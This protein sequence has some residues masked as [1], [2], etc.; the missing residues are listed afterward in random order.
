LERQQLL[1]EPDGLV[2]FSVVLVPDGLA[3]QTA[4]GLQRCS[5]GVSADALA[6]HPHGSALLSIHPKCPASADRHVIAACLSSVEEA[7]GGTRFADVGK[8][9]TTAHAGTFVPAPG[10]GGPQRTARHR[11]RQPPPRGHINL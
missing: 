10:S 4:G 1:V 11:P 3:E 2:R 6:L 5:S 7:A 8:E 9:R